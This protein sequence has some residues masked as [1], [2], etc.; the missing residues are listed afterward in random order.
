M[1]IQAQGLCPMVN[2]LYLYIVMEMVKEDGKLMT[3]GVKYFVFRR[4][5]PI[6]PR[7]PRQCFGPTCHLSNLN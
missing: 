1:D 5:Y 3:N 2:I 7:K 4:L 6:S